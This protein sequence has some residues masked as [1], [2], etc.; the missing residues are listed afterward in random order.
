MEKTKK[1]EQIRDCL[2][3]ERDVEA[4]YL[5]GSYARGKES[6]FSDLD[7]A[8]L[9]SFDLPEEKITD[10][11]IELMTSLSELLDMDVEI[12]ALNRAST[13]F[14]FMVFRESVCILERKPE[15]A[16]SFKAKAIVEYLDFLPLRRHLESRLFAR[17]KEA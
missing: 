16:H 11:K 8:V 13:L 4:A 12:V 17:I 3:R 7:V 9:F 1:I 14:K 6:K 10:R 5:F 15:L 2:A